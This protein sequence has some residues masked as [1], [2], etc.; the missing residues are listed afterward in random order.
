LSRTLRFLSLLLLAAAVWLLIA[1]T[2]G[3]LP[4]GWSES[5]GSLAAAT[6]LA[7]LGGSLLA[8]VVERLLRRPAAGRCGECG[9][10]TAPG[11]S[12]CPR[13]LRDTLDRF[14][15]QERAGV[16]DRRTAGR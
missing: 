10:R 16:Y 4:D 9:S 15:D 6:G 11:R 3:W 5:L 14:Q 8:S 2:A 12:L 13:H 7:C 1:G